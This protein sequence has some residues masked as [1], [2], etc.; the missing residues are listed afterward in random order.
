MRTS[1]S[2]AGGANLYRR[3]YGEGIPNLTAA[4]EFHWFAGNFLKYAAVGRTPGA[5]QERTTGTVDGGR[6]WTRVRWCEPGGRLLAESWT[7]HGLGHDWSGGRA[8]QQYADPSGPDA[9][10]II[11]EVLGLDR[12]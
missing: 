8:G 5:V 12:R 2:G 1:S 4:N 3:N 7:V 10:S 6:S 11:T 9:S